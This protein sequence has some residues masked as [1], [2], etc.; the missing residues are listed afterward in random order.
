ML[1]IARKVKASGVTKTKTPAARVV[2]PNE[3][4]RNSTRLSG[5]SS[6]SETTNSRGM[7][8]A[9]ITAE[10]LQFAAIEQAER[11]ID[12]MPT[13][14]Q[15]VMMS[16]LKAHNLMKTIMMMN[17]MIRRKRKLQKKSLLRLTLRA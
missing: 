10:R 7:N 17:E 14:I 16:S 15:I 1:S 6:V 8:Q 5:N 3:N 12:K 13:K 2:A 9:Q 11:N 4:R